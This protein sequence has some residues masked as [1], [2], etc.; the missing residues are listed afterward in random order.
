MAYVKYTLKARIIERKGLCRTYFAIQRCCY[1]PFADQAARPA[2]PCP[3]RTRRAS[4][5]AEQ[6][7]AGIAEAG[8]DVTLVVEPGV[9]RGCHY[10]DGNGVVVRE[11]RLEPADAFRSREQADGGHAGGAAADQHPDH[12]L[13]RAPGAE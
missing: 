10:S 2:A 5:G 3:R 11:D 7:V 9:H 6:P 4:D 1:W 12:R 8:H 13:Q